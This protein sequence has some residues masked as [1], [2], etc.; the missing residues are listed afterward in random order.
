[1]ASKQVVVEVIDALCGAGKTTYIFDHMRNNSNKK[2][3]F[4][5]PYLNEVG[6][7]DGGG[8][9]QSELPELRFFSPKSNPSKSESF[10]RLVK[11]GNNIAI[12]HKLFIGFTLEVAKAI[13]EQGYHLIIDE[14]IDLVNFYDDVLGADVKILIKANLLLV[15]DNGM[16]EWNYKE[17]PEY[18]GRDRKIKDLCDVGSLWL[19]GEDVIIQRVP[20]ACIQAC[21]SVTILTYMFEGSLMHSWLHLNGIPYSKIYP[22]K[23][24]TSKELKESIR[25]RLNIIEP[26]KTI[27]DI[28]VDSQGLPIDSCFSLSWYNNSKAITLE[29]VKKSVELTL[30]KNMLKGGVF[31]TTF[32]DYQSIMSGVGYSRSRRVPWMD[33]PRSPFLSKNTRASNE[34]RD[35]V[36]CLYMV[37]VYPNTSIEHHLKQF[38]IIVDR[39]KYALSE[40]VQ[41]LFRGSVRMGEDMDILVLSNRMR[42]LLEEWLNNEE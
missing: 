16:L 4:V 13:R 12:T 19:Y 34:Y 25:D 21:E 39:D 2:W 32:V 11:R 38:G 5:S 40:M 31:W 6:G 41:F 10:L 33:T 20:P 9:I 27:L 24:R 28:Q 3:I 35:C 29:S 17:Y 18:N 37:N 26:S 7:D 23:L 1:M 42:T 8:R 14:T 15:G 36:S 22:D 30:K